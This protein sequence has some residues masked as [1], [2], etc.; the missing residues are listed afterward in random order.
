M[1]EI[2]AVGV[3]LGIPIVGELHSSCPMGCLA[4]FGLLSRP[5]PVFPAPLRNLAP[6]GKPE[7][8]YGE[9]CTLLRAERILATKLGRSRHV[10]I[11]LPGLLLLAL[12]LQAADGIHGLRR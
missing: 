6:A 7:P 2:A 8:D 4:G 12:P 11:G 1:S 10:T 9:R 5:K 3:G